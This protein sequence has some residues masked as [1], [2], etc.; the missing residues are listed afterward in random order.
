VV[1][2]L[3]P[4]TLA[5]VLAR[6]PEPELM[7]TTAQA[8]A[9]AW[10][11][12]AASHQAQVDA[13]VDRVGR[14]LGPTPRVLDLACGAAD[15][16]VRTARALPG[17]TILGVDGAAA[18]LDEATRRVAREGLVGRIVLE[19]R[20]LPDSTLGDTEPFDLV[21]CTSAL[22][23]FADPAALWTTVVGAVAPGACVFVADLRRPDEETHVD[24]LVA[25]Y[26]AGES[27]V[28]V[29]DFRNSLRAAYRAE[30]VEAQVG[31]AGLEI[32]VEEL[33]DRHLLAWGRIEHPVRRR[34]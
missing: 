10:A 3:L 16:T 11:D 7:D 31:A 19:R 2:A 26:A 13:M 23:H 34:R 27:P 17:A 14:W 33:G 30:E 1:R 28:L 9:Y 29:D 12:F 6:T 25:R 22:H 4:P 8:E 32:T 15:V 5:A 21:L 20:H 18:M 24:A